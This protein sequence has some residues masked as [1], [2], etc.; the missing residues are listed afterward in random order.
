[1]KMTKKEMIKELVKEFTKK[2]GT[3]KSRWVYNTLNKLKK[4]DVKQQYI[5]LKGK[6]KPF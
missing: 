4:E 5:R 3:K 2:Q 6:I 1:M